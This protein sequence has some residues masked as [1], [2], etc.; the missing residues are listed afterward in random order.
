MSDEPDPQ[1]VRGRA[2]ALLPEEREAGSDDPEAQA[3]EILAD[4]DART[5]DRA[6]PPGKAIE[7]RQ[8]EDT[9]DPT[10]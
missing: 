7:R 3:H 5:D 6:S 9:V 8:S 4:S 2:E 10:D 1:R